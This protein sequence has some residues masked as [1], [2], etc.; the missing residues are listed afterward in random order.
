MP[1]PIDKKAEVLNKIAKGL[2]INL[3]ARIIRED[4]HSY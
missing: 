3:T 2:G 1:N 4:K